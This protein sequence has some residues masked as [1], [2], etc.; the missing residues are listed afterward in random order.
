M[1]AECD[2]LRDEG[3]AYADRLKSAGVK[4]RYTE[5]PGVFHGFA[6]MFGILPEADAALAAAANALR[7]AFAN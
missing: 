7:A 6:S 1:T 4:T 2:P 3:K 5:Y